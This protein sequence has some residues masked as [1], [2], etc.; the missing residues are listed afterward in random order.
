MTEALLEEEI[1]R[2][3]LIGDLLGDVHRTAVGNA[4]R[5]SFLHGDKLRWSPAVGWLHFNGRYWETSDD[6]MVAGYARDVPR[7]ILEQAAESDEPDSG[8]CCVNGQLR[9]RKILRSGQW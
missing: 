9:R 8:P 7:Q 5:L 4:A 2:E 6:V 3:P 1:I